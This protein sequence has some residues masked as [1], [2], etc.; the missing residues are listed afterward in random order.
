MHKKYVCI[1]CRK[2]LFDE[3]SEKEINITCEDHPD[4]IIDYEYS[5]EE[6]NA[7]QEH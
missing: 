7:V 5:I 2:F 6:E 4:Q 3:L 1:F